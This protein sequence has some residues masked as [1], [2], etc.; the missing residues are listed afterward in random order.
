MKTLYVLLNTKGEFFFTRKSVNKG[1]R[2]YTSLGRAK[3]AIN[4]FDKD[5]RQ[6]I[7]IAQYAYLGSCSYE[8]V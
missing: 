5:E 3:A 1:L 4:Q 6:G 8:E 7:E 2:I